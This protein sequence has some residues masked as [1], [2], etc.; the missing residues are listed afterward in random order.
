MM[1]EKGNSVWK[2]SDERS[3]QVAAAV[4][5][6][7]SPGDLYILEGMQFYRHKTS[8]GWINKKY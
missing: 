5:Q 2:H 7:T 3:K 1:L 8:T 4:E 6:D